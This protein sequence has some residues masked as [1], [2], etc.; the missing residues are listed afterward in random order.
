MPIK[1]TT[2]MSTA[3][4]DGYVPRGLDDRTGYYS[5]YLAVIKYP[6]L[7]EYLK[8]DPDLANC[9]QLG[10]YMLVRVRARIKNKDIDRKKSLMFQIVQ[11]MLCA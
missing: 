4:L 9:A 3:L 11:I 1:T 5:M 6:D 2:T 10:R 8:K 7:I